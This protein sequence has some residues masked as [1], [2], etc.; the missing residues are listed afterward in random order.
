M[1]EPPN[2]QNT[3]AARRFTIMNLVR[4]VSVFG[5]AG[6]IAIAR[7]VVAAPYWIGVALA[8][9]GVAAFFFGP[10]ILAKRWKAAD[11]G[12]K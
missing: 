7:E 3:V 5:V 6:G 9:A 11:R 4:I 12:E 2:Q 1:S 8:V 10:A